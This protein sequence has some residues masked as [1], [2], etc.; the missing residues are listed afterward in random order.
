MRS[1]VAIA[2]GALVVLALAY[3]QVSSMA[4]YRFAAAPHSLPAL[5]TPQDGTRL[6]EALER[7]APLPFVEAGLA[8][9]ALQRNDLHAANVYIARM[10]DSAAKWDDEGHVALAE[11][12]G[13]QATADFLAAGD[14]DAVN[15][16]ADADMQAGRLHSALDLLHRLHD[17]LRSGGT[18]PDAVAETSWHMGEIADVLGQKALALQDD[19]EALSLS[20][21][22]EKYLLDAGLRSADLGEYA[23]ARTYFNRMLGV[24][25]RNADAYA[26]FGIIAL[27]QGDLAQARAQAAHSRELDP[28]SPALGRLTRLL[29]Q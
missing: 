16:L 15:R 27:R 18:H 2:A 11:H 29:P 5:F 24:N 12:H 8:Q 20:P 23:Q 26:G 14:I 13:A 21:F 6:Y 10:P 3:V 7:V 19:R 28:Q 17:R 4:L 22:A 25:P 1:R 9:S